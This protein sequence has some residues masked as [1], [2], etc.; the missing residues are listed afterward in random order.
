MT[1]KDLAERA[2]RMAM[3]SSGDDAA[4]QK[5]LLHAAL[6]EARMEENICPNGCGPMV[7]DDPN[8]RHCPA[9]NFHGR[10]NVRECQVLNVGTSLGYAPKL[11]K[12]K[13]P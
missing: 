8:N 11:Q 10:C 2:S 1:H 9:C 4:D 12:K 7:W 5:A 3:P 13:L 6:H